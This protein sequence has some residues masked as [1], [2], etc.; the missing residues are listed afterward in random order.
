MCDV[1]VAGRWQQSQLRDLSVEC[2]LWKKNCIEE[3]KSGFY[4][5]N[6]ECIN[7]CNEEYPF[8][9]EEEDEK[10]CFKK[11]KLF[12]VEDDNIFYKKYIYNEIVTIDKAKIE[13]YI[14]NNINELIFLNRK[15]QAV[16][17]AINIYDGMTQSI[18]PKVNIN[19]CLNLLRS[20]NHITFLIA[21]LEIYRCANKPN[22]IEYTVYVTETGEKIDLALCT[23]RFIE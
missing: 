16:N 6:N 7:D 4:T 9:I 20:Y 21:Q 8:T 5:E 11:C 10:K 22:Q 2:V 17:Y 18:F 14:D 23:E 13:T 15:I 1:F 3:C 19:K 12:Y